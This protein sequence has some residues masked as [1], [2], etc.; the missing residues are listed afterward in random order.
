MK[1][2]FYDRETAP[3]AFHNLIKYVWLPLFVVRNLV[4]LFTNN[5]QLSN[6]LIVVTLISVGLAAIA[7]FGFLEWSPVGWR[8]FWLFV[9][10]ITVGNALGMLYSIFTEEYAAATG[11]LTALIIYAVISIP[12]FFYYRRRK[13]LFFPNMQP[14]AT[15]EDVASGCNLTEAKSFDLDS[16]TVPQARFCR[17]CGVEISPDAEFCHRCGTKVVHVEQTE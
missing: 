14:T 2:R 16:D 1:K 12:V 11:H 7:F 4:S 3:L 6:S 10:A 9:A 8:F 5:G 13:P 17:H 15:E